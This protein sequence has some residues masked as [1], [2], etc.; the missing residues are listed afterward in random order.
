VRVIKEKG[1]KGGPVTTSTSLT[2]K[3][4]TSAPRGGGVLGP[5]EGRQGRKGG[6]NREEDRPKKHIY[7]G[8]GDLI[9]RVCNWIIAQETWR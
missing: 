7:Q 9:G 4:S 1:R 5:N 6:K 2:S 3:E 8:R